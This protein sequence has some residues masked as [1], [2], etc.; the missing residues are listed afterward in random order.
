M[1]T[2]TEKIAAQ[3]QASIAGDALDVR[4]SVRQITLQALSEGRLDTPAIKQVV[5]AVVQGTL[6]G[7]DA[8]GEPGRQAVT[9]AVHG[10]DDALAAAAEATRLALQEAADRGQDYSKQEIKRTLDDLQ[11]LEALFID[12]LSEAA[13]GAGN[14]AADTFKDLA[15]HGRHSGTAVGK[16]VT[17]ALKQL[18]EALLQGAK[19]QVEGGTRMLQTSGALLADMAAGFLTGVAE[20]LHQAA[21]SDSTRR[22]K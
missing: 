3:V 6:Q 9:E 17:V 21:G 5:K 11:G 2:T 15:E 22:D 1:T 8:S 20:R 16:Q 18:G 4:D 14:L 10:L 7:A 13:Q 12:T 19:S